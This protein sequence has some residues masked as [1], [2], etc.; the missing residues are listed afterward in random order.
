[1]KLT[2]L[3]KLAPTPEQHQLLM[4]TMEH[5]NDAC[6]EIAKTAFRLHSAN[7]I[8]LQKYVYYA[9]R[10]AFGLSS[11]MTVRAIS[12]V[13]EAYKRDKSI[14]P[15]FDRHGAMI[16]DDRILSWRIDRASILTLKGRESVPIRIG[17]YQE[18]RMSRIR[19]QADLLLRNGLFYL[20]ATVDA[21]EA[22]PFEPK[23][24]I[25]VDLGIRNIATDS[26]GENW[27]GAEING[28]RARHAELRAKLQS[29]GTTSAKRLLKKRSG[30]EQRYARNVNHVIS[31]RLV[32]K[33]KDTERG[34]ALEDLTGI[35]S[36]ITVRKAQ[37]RTQHS[38]GF[39]QLRA[40]VAYKAKA[41]GVPVLLINPRNTSRTCPS[42]GGIDKAN[43][44]TRD[45]FRCVSCGFSGAADHVA[46][47]NIRRAAVNQPYAG[48]RPRVN[49]LPA[50]QGALALGS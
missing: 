13:C 33:A 26:D 46:A 18:E 35:R 16:Y 28:V 4:D 48:E 8:E 39:Y 27:S 9:T 7:K 23:D 45:E 30:K 14:I 40:F 44:P 29:K 15:V 25:G 42:C 11:Q 31:K 5:F 38:W 10:E 22:P 43:R 32:A 41:V 19:G 47:E 34:L 21:P 36:R 1:M 20:A 17:P 12:K 49:D 3:V 24:W 37:R 50:S 6:N 2:L